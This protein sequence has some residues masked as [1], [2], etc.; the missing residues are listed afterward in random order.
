MAPPSYMLKVSISGIVLARF[1]GPT[2]GPPGSCRPQLGPMLT[3]W[4]LLSRLVHPKGYTCSCLFLFCSCLITVGLHISFHITPLVLFSNRPVAQIPQWISPISHNAPFKQKCAHL[5]IFL[6]PNG[7]LKDV[8]LM[9]C[10]ICEMDL[11]VKLHNTGM[12]CMTLSYI[13]K[14][15]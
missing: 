7:T 15:I 2:W 6:W 12:F 1:M 14:G 8:C 10:G 5:C 13:F 4:T 11:F 9:H 3:P